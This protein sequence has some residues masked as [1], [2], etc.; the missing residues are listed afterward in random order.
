MS[1]L[2]HRSDFEPH[3]KKTFQ[4]HSESA[5]IVKVTLVEVTGKNR[6]GME[7]FSLIFKGPKEPVLPQM[8]YKMK[9][10]KVGEFRIFLVPIVSGEQNAVLYQAIINRRT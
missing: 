1:K 6:E 9:Q 4:V 2:I 3:L 7:S 8:T 10:T 5:G